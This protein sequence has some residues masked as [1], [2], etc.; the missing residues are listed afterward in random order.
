MAKPVLEGVGVLVTR[1]RLQAQGLVEAIEALG[2]RA[3]AFPAIEARPRSD[4]DIAAD[5]RALRTPDIAIFVSGNAVRWGLPYAGPGRIAAIGPATAAR[6]EASGRSVD[7]RSQQGYDSERLLETPELRDVDG[8]VV[9]IIRGD[10]GRELLAT[11]LRERGAIVEYLAVYSR[12]VP[13]HTDADIDALCSQW[14]SGGIDVVT[15]MSVE[16]LVNL[17]GLLPRECR[18]AMAKTPLVTPATR[19]IKEAERRFPGIPT[20]VADGP[21][22]G[23]MVEAV[24]ACVTSRTP[25]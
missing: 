24:V 16:T 5:A 6:L 15:I 22:A 10:G 2:G 4:A 25:R 23:D 14:I 21:Q 13:A 19:V 8:K 1:P 7:I 11:V 18:Q 20:T 12:E 3:I 17:V 9:R